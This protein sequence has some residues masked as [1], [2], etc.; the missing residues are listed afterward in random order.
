MVLGPVLVRLQTLWLK[1][2]LSHFHMFLSHI[3][4]KKKYREELNIQIEIICIMT[5]LFDK[6]LDIFNFS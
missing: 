5:E 2:C 6:M 3:G 1:T 4:T